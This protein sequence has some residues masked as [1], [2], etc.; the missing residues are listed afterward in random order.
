[1]SDVVGGGRGLGLAISIKLAAASCR[2]A[3]KNAARGNDNVL[4][5]VQTL[6]I[7]RSGVRLRTAAVAHGSL[8]F[9]YIENAFVMFFD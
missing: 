3:L 7:E 6:K 2:A 1:M 8:F 4:P 9:R 5:L